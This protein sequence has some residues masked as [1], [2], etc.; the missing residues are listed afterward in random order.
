MSDNNPII[1]RTYAGAWHYE[2]KIY[3]LGDITLPFP[4]NLTQLGW[5]GTGF[6]GVYLLAQGI[7]VLERIPLPILYGA[8]PFLFMKLLTRVKFHGKPTVL[9]IRGFFRHLLEP[10]CQERFHPV[11]EHSSAGFTDIRFRH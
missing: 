10:A 8:C 1:L 6:V 7:P 4:I 3:M 5:F 9:W 11:R 2:K